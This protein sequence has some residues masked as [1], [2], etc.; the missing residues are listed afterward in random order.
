MALEKA[1]DAVEAL[2]SS[3]ASAELGRSSSH[4]DGTGMKRDLERRHVNMIALAGMIVSDNHRSHDVLC[5]T[6]PPPLLTYL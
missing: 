4:Q 5:S 6:S 3:S 1:M 2:D